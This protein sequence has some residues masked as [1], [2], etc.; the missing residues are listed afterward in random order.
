MLDV[1][2]MVDPVLDR[3]GEVRGHEL[4]HWQSSC[5]DSDSSLTPP[6][7]HGQRCDWDDRDL[8]DVIR[9]RDACG[10]IDNWCQEP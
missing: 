1:A 9:G 3:G 2:T 6:E 10:R 4:Y 5:G 8:R 7:E